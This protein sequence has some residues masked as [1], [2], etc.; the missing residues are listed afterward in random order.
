MAPLR[1]P[2][3]HPSMFAR[4]WI[5]S[6]ITFI[7]GSA[8]I[9]PC[10]A[11]APTDAPDAAAHKVLD[12]VPAEMMLGY[13]R[14][15][16]GELADHHRPV[17]TH[18]EWLIRRRLLRQRL[19]QS[20]GEFPREARTPPDA[21]IT[22]TIDHGDHTVEKVVYQSLPGLYVSALVYV[23]KHKNGPVPAV[24]CVNGHWPEAKATSIIQK[25]CMMLAKLGIIAFCQDVIGTGERAACDG[26]PPTTYHGFYRGA[27]PRIV[28]R[29]L[30]GYIM[31]E[32]LRAADYLASRPDVDATKMMCTGASGGGK[33]SMFFPALD[34]R[35]L[36]GVPVCYISSYVEHM[37]AT[38]CVGEIPTGVLR[39]TDQWEILGLHAPRP[40]LALAAT[41][42]VSV[43][44]PEHA[45][46]TLDRAARHVY[47][48]YGAEKRVQL[49]TF[50]SKHDYNRPMR[51]RFYRHAVRH[52]LGRRDV[53]VRE[54]DDLPVEP[55]EMLRCG[56][57]ASSEN[58]Q[59]LTYRRARQLASAIKLPDACGRWERV[60]RSVRS[61]LKREI[62]GG[63]PD[64]SAAQSRYVR[65]RTWKGYR[66]QHWALY[67][68]PGI[69]VPVV[70]CLPPARTL[71]SAGRGVVIIDESGKQHAFAR[72][73]VERLLEEGIVVLAIDY[74]GA[75]ETAGT[76]P[77]IGYGPAAPDYN[78]S[79][80]A[81][82][83]GRPL[84]G[85]RV[86]D[87]RCALDLLEQHP[88]AHVQSMVVAGRGRG[89]LVALLTAALDDRVT[90][91]VL[92]Q[93]LA[94]WIFPEE[95]LDIGIS[96]L[97]P[98]VLTAGDI[99]H[100]AACLAPRSTLVLNP[101]DGRHRRLSADQAGRWGPFA[102]G[103]YGLYDAASHLEV[104]TVS[105]DAV[106][107]TITTWLCP[108]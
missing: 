86:H 60:R 8:G 78:L 90:A 61:R 52:L 71:P 39:Y 76:V 65:T 2:R 43:F 68:E 85:M 82:L 18:S 10:E 21:R 50:D 24:I 53:D 4:K 33:Q 1:C 46:A 42:D 48:L 14:R 62:L 37:G 34:D 22:G 99:Q 12:H 81:L 91:T 55:A 17:A 77:S 54:P 36:G 100:L 95:F 80:Y 59:S 98:R 97:I 49:G 56:L 75:G 89:A 94:S 69:C 26:T 102:S 30:L 57:P 20:L 105:S 107:G 16:A 27:A 35:L 74:R 66:L 41:Q 51:Q 7:L 45:A 5:P 13:F 93:L 11:A 87:V 83:V 6:A 38:A 92:E 9:A 15:V 70:L 23:P 64:R 72:G 88:D 19:W 58:L 106:P 84:A 108:R 31:Y 96:S 32:C 67:S 73:L 40:L 79:N 47:R 101:V 3:D 29:S 44:A 63:F 25:R 104:L 28:D 103:V